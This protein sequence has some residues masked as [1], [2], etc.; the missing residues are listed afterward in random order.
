MDLIITAAAPGGAAAASSS[1]IP[2]HSPRAYHCAQLEH[3]GHPRTTSIH[4]RG[5]CYDESRAQ[6]HGLLSN[7][8][9]AAGRPPQQSR[10]VRSCRRLCGRVRIPSHRLPLTDHAKDPRSSRDMCRSAGSAQVG[11][12]KVSAI[13]PRDRPGLQ[14]R[15][16][17]VCGDL[18]SRYL[19]RRMPRHRGFC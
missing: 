11:L 14:E 4:T 5:R 7:P 3:S 9:A 15:G 8:D 16:G 17:G 6:L 13:P 1:A 12:A 10:S 18:I 2:H 19:S